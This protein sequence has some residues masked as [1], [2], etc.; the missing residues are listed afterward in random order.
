MLEFIYTCE[1]P[2]LEIWIFLR[3]QLNINKTL[4]SI[5]V[6]SNL[7]CMYIIY[8][9][10]Y[11]IILHIFLCRP[12]HEEDKQPYEQVADSGVQTRGCLPVLADHHETRRLRAGKH[13][14]HQIVK[15]RIH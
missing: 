11:K 1:N 13:D 15:N 12:V 3:S 6:K 7:Y 4:I 9:T 14:V 5:V 10:Y 8:I 2:L